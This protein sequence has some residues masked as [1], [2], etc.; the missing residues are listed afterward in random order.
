MRPSKGQSYFDRVIR[1]YVLG[2]IEYLLHKECPVAGPLLA[3]LVNGIN[4]VAGSMYD[5][6]TNWN[7][8]EKET[9]N[10]G[11]FLTKVMGLDAREKD[12]LGEVFYCLIR[13]GVAHEGVTK[14]GVRFG[15]HY[16]RPDGEPFLFGDTDGY[17]VLNVAQLARRFLSVVRNLDPA[18]FTHA[19]KLDEDSVAL[20]YE[21]SG[22]LP[23]LPNDLTASE[24][25]EAGESD[26]E[27]MKSSSSAL[28]APLNE[29]RRNPFEDMAGGDSMEDTSC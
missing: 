22:K 4:A 10:I 28:D 12:L 6:P 2:D 23:P 27:G 21:L 13:C 1:E 14:L 7:T 9:D 26:G 8:T 24:D 3:V 29:R 5:F 25:Q 18:K 15:V 17:V 16:H 11:R 19:P 20:V